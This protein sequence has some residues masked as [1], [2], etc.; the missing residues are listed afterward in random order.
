MLADL[1]TV[2]REGPI[3]GHRRVKV[4]VNAEA[5]KAAAAVGGGNGDTRSR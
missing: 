4:T 5:G 3:I 1:C 2:V